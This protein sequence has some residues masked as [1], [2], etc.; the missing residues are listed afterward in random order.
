MKGEDLT[1]FRNAS[2][3][4]FKHL[5][6]FSW[7]GKCERLGFDEIWLDVTENILFNV[8]K[9]DFDRPRNSFF[10][11]ERNND[12][13]GFS[14][15]ASTTQGNVFPAHREG[16]TKVEA[17]KDCDNDF[18]L[19]LRLKMASHFAIHIR[20]SLAG[21]KGYTAAVG[22]STNKLLSKLVGNLAKPNN[23]TTLVPPYNA[24]PDGEMSNVRRF[25]DPFEI[26]KLPGIGFKIA[27]ILKNEPAVAPLKN[28]KIY[29]GE[30][31]KAVTVGDVR[32]ALSPE[33][34]E[35]IFSGH[36]LK[37][38]I[39]INVWEWI[40]GNDNSEVR[41]ATTIPSQISLEDSYLHLDGEGQVYTELVKLS[42]ALVRRMRL[43]LTEEPHDDHTMHNN[44]PKDGAPSTQ[45]RW[46]AIP[47]TARLTIRQR[48]ADSEN[49]RARSFGRV[50][51]STALP[52]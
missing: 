19:G 40:H 3:D 24:G 52:A 44:A 41:T 25:L 37:R 20:Q 8:D 38:D 28:E 33:K 34:L 35:K 11:L 6:P 18:F 42:D 13:I 23:Q 48:A 10:Q 47:R 14:Y 5:S 45:P 36:G 15:D 26:G 27:N 17:S 16:S 2:K 30:S 46:I 1:I 22:V 21:E 43:D 32:R 50:S 29:D 39:S 49:A 7:N 9:V 12:E 4:L 31:K 51:R